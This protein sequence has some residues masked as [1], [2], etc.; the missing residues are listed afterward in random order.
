MQDGTKS[1]TAGDELGYL[2]KVKLFQKDAKLYIFSR[3]ASTLGYGI[4]NVIFNLYMLEVGFGEDFLGFFL[5]VSMFATAGIAI[6]A[7]MITDRKSRKRIL[8]AASFVSFISTV[9]RFTAIQPYVLLFSQVLLGFS[10]AFTQVAMTPYVSDVSTEKERA[11]LFG[12]SGGLSLLA[13]LAGNILG[14]YIPGLVRNLGLAVNLLWSYR[15]TLWFSLVPIAIS[16]LALVPMTRDTPQE[17]EQRLGF[18]NVR[19]WEFIGKYTITTSTIGLGAG[20]I[21]LYFNLYFKQVF[22]VDEATIG[23]IFAIN[24][25]LLSVG[26]FSAP[27]LADRIGK[28]KTVIITEALSIPFL[29]MLGWAPYLYIGVLAYVSRTVLMNMAGPVSNAFFMEGLTKEERATAVGITRT[30]DSFVRGVAAII[31]GWLLSLGLYRIPYLLVS[32]LYMLGVLLFYGF[33]K[34]KEKELNAMR[35]ARIKHEEKAQE[36]PDVT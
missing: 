3:V 31:G 13:V 26:Q 1:L 16:G 15:L 11:H 17:S 36:A 35:E 2:D 9:I 10:Q 6:A 24:T 8:L 25:I 12:F 30:G 32:G 23:L 14:G 18:A 4:S 22:Q 28:V 29:L 5:S 21:V 19:N 7:G 20:V 34:G 27:A 33:F